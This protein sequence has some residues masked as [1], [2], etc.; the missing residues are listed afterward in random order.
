MRSTHPENAI[1]KFRFSIIVL[2]VLLPPLLYIGTVQIM[3]R[4]A[5]SS[6]QAGLEKTYLGN[7]QLLLNGL[8]TI[9]S[10]I[11]KNVDAY[12]KKNCWIAWGAKAQVTV[13]TQ[14]NTLLYPLNDS[15]DFNTPALDTPPIEI[16]AENFKLLNEGPNLS[17]EFHLPHNSPITNTI[18]AFYIILS[19][20]LLYL[21]YRRWRSR[22]NFQMERQTQT[23]QQLSQKSR[24][25]EQQLQSM[26][27]E[28]RHL[29]SEVEQM[30]TLL[31]ETKQNAAASEEEMMEEIIELEAKIAEKIELQH[32]HQLDVDELQE[33]IKQLED[34]LQKEQGR[35]TKS[36]ET[37][38]KRLTILYKNLVIS[39]RAVLGY[40][41]LT[42]DFKLKCE[43]VIHQLNADPATVPV[44]RKVFGKKNRETVF[45]VVFSYKGRFYY[46]PIENQK[47]QILVIG[48]K[49]SQQ[50][51]LEYLNRL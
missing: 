5:A 14:K 37:T 28:R 16:A 42:E 13:K 48:T 4:Y 51:D 6:L 31:A 32:K 34:Q 45:E 36:S 40:L 20:S 9:Q 27:D 1:V 18:L 33:K 24:Q 2:C 25:F 19:L 50:K 12:L 46:R 26:Q 8:L 35:K 11:Q 41:D 47:L 21:Y 10:S 17:L 15:Q 49:N 7:T 43:E 44:K 30:Q 23:Q 39:D 38:R 3:E 22:L 29:D